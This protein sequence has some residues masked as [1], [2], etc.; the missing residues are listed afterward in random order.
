MSQHALPRQRAGRHRVG[1]PGRV[2]C[3]D[4]PATREF[5][6]MHARRRHWWH[7]FSVSRSRHSLEWMRQTG[8][9]ARPVLALILS[10]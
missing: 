10:L 4:L 7:L 2:Y 3:R 5:F 6:A 8:Q 9:Q 1:R